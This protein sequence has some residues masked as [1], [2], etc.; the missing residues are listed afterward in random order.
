MII[1]SSLLHISWQTLNETELWGG[2]RSA[3]FS[4]HFSIYQC[5]LK[6]CNTMD[7]LT[8][9]ITIYPLYKDTYIVTWTLKHYI[10]FTCYKTTLIMNV[11]SMSALFLSYLNKKWIL[12]LTGIKINKWTYIFWYCSFFSISHLE[13]CTKT[14]QK[15]KRQ[16]YCTF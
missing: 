9:I 15:R 11:K 14:I 16:N 13:P 4:Y 5:L 10:Q 8:N 3:V 1:L 7:R 6:L 12:W 2:K